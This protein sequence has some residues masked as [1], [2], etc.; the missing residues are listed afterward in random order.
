MP[1]VSEITGVPVNR[2]NRSSLESAKCWHFKVTTS[3]VRSMEKPHAGWK[4]ISKNCHWIRSA[5]WLK[6]DRLQKNPATQ[7]RPGIQRHR[8]LSAGLCQPGGQNHDPATIRWKLFSTKFQHSQHG[9]G[10]LVQIVLHSF[11]CQPRTSEKRPVAVDAKRSSPWWMRRT[12]QSRR[13]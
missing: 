4:N 9:S 7:A 6:K 3:K 13:K 5:C 8:L 11:D 10:L 12:S 1:S 2:S